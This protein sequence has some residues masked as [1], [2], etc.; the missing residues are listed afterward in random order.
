MTRADLIQRGVAAY[1]AGSYAKATAL[2][3]MASLCDQ[4]TEV[5]GVFDGVSDADLEVAKPKNQ[6]TQA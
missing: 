4:P 6:E 1:V 5:L 3:L 2:F